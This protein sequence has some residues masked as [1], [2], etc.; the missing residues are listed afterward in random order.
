MRTVWAASN[1]AGVLA[2]SWMCLGF[3]PLGDLALY[4]VQRRL[5]IDLS[6]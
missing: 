5:E 4:C 2:L 3:G 6:G 1:I